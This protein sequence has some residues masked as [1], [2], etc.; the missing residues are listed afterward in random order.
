MT[1]KTT[2]ETERLRSRTRTP[3]TTRSGTTLRGLLCD[4]SASE[5]FL[6]E[7]RS[8]GSQDDRAFDVYS[9]RAGPP[10]LLG[11]VDAVERRP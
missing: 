11:S 10:H 8:A 4:A 3:T 5:D 9:A 1:G 7:P 6:P 2:H